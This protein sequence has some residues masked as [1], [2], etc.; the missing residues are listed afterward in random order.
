MSADWIFF[1]YMFI[2]LNVMAF[3]FAYC[4]RN[5]I[6][7]EL[8]VSFFIGLIWPFVVLTALYFYL[9]NIFAKSENKNEQQ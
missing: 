5:N 9:I 3:S 6:E 2:A 1:G 4:V 7:D 8:W